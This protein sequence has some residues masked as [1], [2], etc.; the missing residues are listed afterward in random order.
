MYCFF[1]MNQVSD[2]ADFEAHT[3]RMNA[4]ST[5]FL[6]YR[7]RKMM[8]SAAAMAVLRLWHFRRPVSIPKGHRILRIETIMPFF[9][10]FAPI[11]QNGPS[12]VRLRG[13]CSF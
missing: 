8:E 11:H 6:S 3:G 13:G 4:S 7:H 5:D 10:Q 12:A 2:C 1:V 9:L